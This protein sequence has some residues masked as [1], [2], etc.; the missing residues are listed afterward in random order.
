MV[1]R[2]AIPVIL[3]A[4]VST[5]PAAA[6]FITYTD[7]YDWESSFDDLIATE[8]FDDIP[9]TGFLPLNTTTTVGLIDVYTFASGGDIFRVQ[10]GRVDGQVDRGPGSTPEG[11]TIIFPYAISA[12]GADFVDACSAGR[13]TLQFNTTVVALGD[14]M[15]GLC[16]GFF[17]FTSDELFTS[18]TFGQELGDCCNEVFQMDNVSFATSVPEPDT[19]A[20]L[21]IGLAGIGLARRKERPA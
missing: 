18:L 13:L 5:G 21:G 16:T 17:G 6:D 3:A 9:N 10:F 14:D 12:F 4:C 15:G 1:L 11:F 7:R 20:L 2:L 19:L 8:D